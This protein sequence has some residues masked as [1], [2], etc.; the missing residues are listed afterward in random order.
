MSDTTR[1]PNGMNYRSNS[2]KGKEEAKN[3]TG[4]PEKD[5]KKVVTGVVVQ[6]K[7]S[8]GKRIT[9]A[10]TG[11]DTKS[12]GH[13]VLFEVILPTA[14]TLVTDIVTQGVERMLYGESSSRQG[15]PRRGYNNYSRPS[16]N[17]TRPEPR[18]MTMQSRSVH[19][20]DEIVLHDRAEADAV[21]DQLN[22][23]ISNYDVATVADLLQ[24]VGVTGS[25]TDD[26]WG[27]YDLRGARAERVR[28]GYLL[29][30]P[31]TQPIE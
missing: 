8:L 18:T 20:F 1:S 11:D 24:L 25:F 6:R 15:G 26:K 3:K 31:K 10:F 17:N 13:Y 19:N 21:I 5:V 2:N 12:V 22:D 16:S 29:R 14:K 30:L 28:D 27:W 4:K 9:D 23:L 7:R